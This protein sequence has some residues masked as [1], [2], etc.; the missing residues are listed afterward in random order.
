MK[1]S[2]RIVNYESQVIKW[3]PELVWSYEASWRQLES[4]LPK[5]SDRL[6]GVWRLVKAKGW[7]DLV[8]QTSSPS[9]DKTALYAPLESL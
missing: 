1:T 7:S 9:K 3:N 4:H 8:A 5:A 6:N 2:I